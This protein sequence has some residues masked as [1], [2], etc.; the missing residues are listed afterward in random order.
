MYV[1][2]RGD[3]SSCFGVFHIFSYEL[4]VIPAQID[5]TPVLIAE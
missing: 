2:V 1:G 3:T 5:L 4:R